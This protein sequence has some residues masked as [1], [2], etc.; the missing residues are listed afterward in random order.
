MV[1][2]VHRF[3]NVTEFQFTDIFSIEMTYRELWYRMSFYQKWVEEDES[4]KFSDQEK[5]AHKTKLKLGIELARSYT[6][7]SSIAGTVGVVLQLMISILVAKC[8]LETRA[9]YLFGGEDVLL[10]TCLLYFVHFMMYNEFLA[11]GIYKKKFWKGV[12][13]L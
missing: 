4:G 13:L 11:I 8:M 6:L 2:M 1:K 12:C 9:I 7:R 10:R 5:K 3:L